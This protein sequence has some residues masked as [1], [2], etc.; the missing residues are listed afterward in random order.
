MSWVGRPSIGGQAGWRTVGSWG[1]EKSGITPGEGRKYIYTKQKT[2]P[3][4]QQAREVKPR[5]ETRILSRSHFSGYEV[6]SEVGGGRERYYL[7]KAKLSP[8]R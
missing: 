7:W 6:G 1:F 5:V 4:F 2:T 8:R 3:K